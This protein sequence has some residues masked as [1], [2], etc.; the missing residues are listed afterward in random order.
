MLRDSG[1]LAVRDFVAVVPTRRRQPGPV[2]KGG[3]EEGV[4]VAA[5]GVILVGARGPPDAEVV[6]EASEVAE[7]V[8]ARGGGGG[9]ADEDLGDA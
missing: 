6:E 1:H 7:L 3:V 4:G 5:G 2:H 8:G 9:A